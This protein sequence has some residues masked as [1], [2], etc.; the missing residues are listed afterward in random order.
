MVSSSSSLYFDILP[1][2]YSKL[3]AHYSSIYINYF[4]SIV[5]ASPSSKYGTAIA[6]NGVT[7]N[8]LFTAGLKGKVE[9]P[10]IARVSIAAAGATAVNKEL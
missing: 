6:I 4:L 3:I 2:T 1:A 9:P 5:E 7:M 8:L 10:T